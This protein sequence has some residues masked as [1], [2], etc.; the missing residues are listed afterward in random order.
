M[1]TLPCNG[2][3]ERRRGRQVGPYLAAVCG[4]GKKIMGGVGVR[5]STREGLAV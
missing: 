1:K 4:C 5:E 2:E 3:L